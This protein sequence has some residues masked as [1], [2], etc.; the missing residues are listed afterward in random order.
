[1][2]LR[3]YTSVYHIAFAYA[4][5]LSNTPYTFELLL[6]GPQSLGPQILTPETPGEAH[7]PIR[8]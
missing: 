8:L 5:K 2:M 4:P 6:P 7:D 1:M 3:F